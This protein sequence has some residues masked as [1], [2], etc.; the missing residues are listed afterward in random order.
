MTDKTTADELD[1]AAQNAKRTLRNLMPGYSSF[2]LT[3]EIELHH[4]VLEDY[5]KLESTANEISE[6]NINLTCSL[7]SEHLTQVRQAPLYL[8][9][10]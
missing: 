3:G 1:T 5:D 10:R 8:L 2:D 9:P 4:L 7:P 6:E